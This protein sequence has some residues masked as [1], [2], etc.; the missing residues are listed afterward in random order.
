MK[1]LHVPLS[2]GSLGKNDGCEKAPEAIMKHFME[3]CLNERGVEPTFRVDTLI[4]TKNDY[5]KNY[6]QLFVQEADVYLG[7]DHS[8]TYYTFKKFSQ[9]HKN[10][11]IIIFDAHPDCLDTDFQ[12]IT[13][14][15]FLFHL[16]QEGIVKPQ[17]ILLVGVRSID[18]KE[19]AFLKQHH[20]KYFSMKDLFGNFEA[21]C[22]SIMEEARNWDGLYLSIDIDVLDPAFA[23]G[24][25]YL[26]PGGLTTRELLYFVQRIKLLKHLAKIDLVE[27]NPEKD[28]KDMTV[29][30]AAKI[31][32]ELL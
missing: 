26:E 21:V 31:L 17:N 29:R 1:I 3:L 14:E 16:V 24:T 7:G 19:L 15:D 2:Q 10:P 8:L 18:A 11:G 4:V 28:V 6:E 5:E 12:T 23:P 30:V 27:V 9:E 13:H 25:G 32:K 22:D 20:I